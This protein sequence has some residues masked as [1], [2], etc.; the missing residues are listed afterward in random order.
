MLF[1]FTTRLNPLRRARPARVALCIALG[2]VP[3]FTLA[4]DR[5]YDELITMAR[6]GNSAPALT[7]FPQ[8]AAH[9]DLTASEI[10][11][12]LQIAG[13]AGD[14][15]QV[16][17]T[18][19]RYQQVTLPVRG[20]QAAARALRNLKQWQP[21]LSVWRSALAAEPANDDLHSGYIM[22][23]ADAGQR[24]E[25]LR[26][27]QQRRQQ[28]DT[29]QHWLDLA[30]AQRAAGLRW[31]ALQ[32]SS[33]AETRYPGLLNVQQNYVSALALNRVSGEALRA[34]GQSQPAAAELRRLQSD[35]L[36]EQVRIAFSASR[37]EAERFSVADRALAGYERL[38][39]AWQLQPEAAGDVRR[40]RI[41][42]L[43]ALVA[44]RQMQKA[45]DEYHQLSAG[46]AEV[47]AYA[48]RWVASAYLYLHQPEQAV[49]LYQSVRRE[50]EI[51]MLTRRE[52]DNLFYAHAEA[53]Q[54]EEARQQSAEYAAITPYYLRIYGSPVPQPNDR[55]LSARQMQVQAAVLNDDLP[56]AQQ[57][58]E[59]LAQ[60]APANQSLQTDLAGV[61]L[62]R[63]WPRQ[64]EALLKRAESLEPR[65]QALESQ[66]AQTAL[67]LQ[68]WHQAD[69]LADDVLA[70]QPESRSAQRLDRLRNVHRYYQLRINA[71]HGIDSDSPVSGAN[72]FSLDALLYGPPI[73]ENWR[74]FSG[75]AFAD[76]EYREGKALNRSVRGG[77]EY[78]ARDNWAE[79]EL[80]GQ[81]Y[82]SG[83]K[84]GLRLAG[85]HDLSDRWRVG[86][87]AERLMRNAPLRALRDGV[88]VDGGSLFARWRQSE[89]REWQATLSP[90]WFSDGNRRLEWSLAGKERL[91]TAARYSLDFT[92][93]LSGS[94][95]SKT[96]GAY[97]SP[98]R[99][100][101]LVP[102]V[103]LDHLLYRHYQTEWRQQV[104][105]GAGRYWQQGQ[106]AGAVTRV[107][108]GQRVRWN[109]VL[110]SGVTLSW[111]K[112]PYD[113]VREKNLSVSFDMNYRF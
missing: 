91:F 68:E 96:D 62:M 100:L 51:G 105:V 28:G 92:P 14:D 58:A 52:Q 16:V 35:A 10:A 94:S 65:N 88:T 70:R 104:E 95:N 67:A 57:R 108:Y 60:T 23:L 4:Q 82:G 26:L 27:A 20:Q 84:T 22:T 11:D 13:W 19:Q 3:P 1:T 50:G 7:F 24:A 111:D 5:H 41:D 79:L 53:E 39:Q 34:S 47:P 90:S 69:L 48:R 6:A 54:A 99:D 97:Y 72:D 38:L 77:V 49:A 103:T 73:E 9:R 112:R 2:L 56:L 29:A 44:R 66:Q 107:S 110:D 93:S 101:S 25:A 86:G 43:G 61:L 87:S 109:D 89:R 12:W 21:A 30:Y 32:S 45:I 59:K 36:A 42:R 71:E 8:Q 80:N 37:S 75:L 106:Q 85:W 64:A 83:T 76:S 102:G 15:R 40:A 78:R 81:R 17:A 63:G 18:W 31:D 98:S 46:G 74:L 113:G 33:Q 55:W